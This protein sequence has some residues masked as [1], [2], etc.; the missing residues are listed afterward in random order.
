MST[1]KRIVKLKALR[2]SDRGGVEDALTG[3]TTQK[4]AVNIYFTVEASW[5]GI[6]KIGTIMPQVVKKFNLSWP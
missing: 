3:A 6:E 4:N 2:K 5:T 1:I